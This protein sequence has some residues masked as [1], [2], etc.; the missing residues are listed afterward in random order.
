MTPPH[1][2]LHSSGPWD[3]NEALNPSSFTCFLTSLALQSD[4]SFSHHQAVFPQVY[5]HVRTSYWALLLEGTQTRHIHAIF[6]FSPIW[7]AV[8][9]CCDNTRVFACACWGVAEQRGRSATVQVALKRW[10]TRENQNRDSWSHTRSA[11]EELAHT[12]TRREGK[13][14]RFDRRRWQTGQKSMCKAAF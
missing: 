4:G 1:T 14:M 5:S 3:G 8:N 13:Q 2:H 6:L 10:A 11:V 12:N 9:V 7:C